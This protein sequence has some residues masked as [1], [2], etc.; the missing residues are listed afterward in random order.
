MFAR[1]AEDLGDA[2]GSAVKAVQKAGFGVA[3]IEIDP[4]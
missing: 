4:N 1:E 2:I 3:K